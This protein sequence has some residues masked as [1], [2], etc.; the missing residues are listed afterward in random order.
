MNKVNI[1][2]PILFL[3]LLISCQTNWITETEKIIEK[4]DKKFKLIKEIDTI[5]NSQIETNIQLFRFDDI[6][7]LKINFKMSEY[8]FLIDLT[9]IFYKNDTIIFADKIYGLTPLIYKRKRKNDEPPSELIERISYFKNKKSGIE[10]I[11]RIPFYQN[12]NIESKRK[13]LQKLEFEIKEIG[14]KEYSE[15][16]YQFDRYIKY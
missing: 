6:S 9:Q 11:R 4:S 5:E 12:D 7:K 8:G 16:E 3:G 1:L 10:K 14:E 13:E 15:I 2:L